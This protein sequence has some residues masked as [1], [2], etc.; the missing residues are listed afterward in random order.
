MAHIISI[1]LRKGGSG[2]T[3]TSVNLAAGLHKKGH[4][5]LLVDLDD[6]AN[7]TMCVGVNPFE[8]ERSISTLFTD[9]SLQP[10]DVILT[11][12]FGLPLLPATQNLEDVAAGMNATSTKE[13]KNILD[14]LRGEFDYIIIDTQPGHSFMSI[15]ALIASDYVLI[16]LQAHYLAMEGLARILTDIQKVQHGNT[17]NSYRGPNPHLQVLGIIPCMVQGTNISRG[18]ISKTREDYPGLVLPIEI[19]LLVDFVNSTLEGV[20]LVIAKPQHPGAVEYMELVTILEN[21]LEGK[22]GKK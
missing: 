11:T 19:K 18:V 21:M 17:L 6:Q 4:R 10:Q 7:A 2:K 16:P 12:D 5:V 13:L 22:H 14:P 8:L 15:G 1:A 20:P 3:T 9:I